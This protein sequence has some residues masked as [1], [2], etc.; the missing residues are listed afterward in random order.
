MI[1]S[2]K[3]IFVKNKSNEI[4]FAIILYF[5]LMWQDLTLNLLTSEYFKI[6]KMPCDVSTKIWDK[7]FNQIYLS[8]FSWTE[9]DSP[10]NKYIDIVCHIQKSLEKIQKSK[11]TTNYFSMWFLYSYFH[12]KSF[13]Y[14]NFYKSFSIFL[15]SLWLI[16]TNSFRIS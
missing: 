7:K 16:I 14:I 15:H 10:R 9:R 8:S 6:Q 12:D 2:T 4:L 3:I 11:T 5:Q 1:F 13:D